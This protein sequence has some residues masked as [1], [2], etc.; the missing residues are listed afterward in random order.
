MEK[1]NNKNVPSSGWRLLGEGE[2]GPTGLGEAA[3]RQ[4]K[5]FFHRQRL[6]YTY[7][8]DMDQEQFQLL[9][10]EFMAEMREFKA[11]MYAFKVEMHEFKQSS[12]NRFSLIDQNLEYLHEQMRDVRDEVRDLKHAVAGLQKQTLTLQE[13]MYDIHQARNTVK[14]KFG[15]EWG[16]VSTAIAFISSL[17]ASVLT[18]FA[19]K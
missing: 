17:M 14:I 4:S 11:E 2:G 15:W 6:F 8:W 1:E 5:A 19:W 16:A 13:K 12:E 18:K 3:L 9:V 10:I 7:N